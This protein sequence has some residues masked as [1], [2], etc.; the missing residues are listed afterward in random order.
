MTA[1]R[2]PT[3][4]SDDRRTF[5]RACCDRV[6]EKGGWFPSDADPYHHPPKVPLGRD[7][8]PIEFYEFAAESAAL[9]P[10]PTA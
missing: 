5:L 3:C 4:G 10:E 6:T 2:C 1:P 7:W 9:T 8:V